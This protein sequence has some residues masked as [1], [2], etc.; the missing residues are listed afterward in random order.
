MHIKFHWLFFIFGKKSC[1]FF[2]HL[3]MR[4]WRQR[5]KFTWC[6]L[7]VH[8]IFKAG[9]QGLSLRIKC[10]RF[11]CN[12]S[13]SSLN[14]GNVALELLMDDMGWGWHNQCRL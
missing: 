8:F 9:K 7:Y 3:Y 2:H 1:S 14:G 6:G 12:L 13:N 10:K 11:S 5:I 4:S